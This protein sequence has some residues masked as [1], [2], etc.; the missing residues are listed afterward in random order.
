M[1]AALVP[2]RWQDTGGGYMA[3]SLPSNVTSAIDLRPIAILSDANS[4]GYAVAMLDGALPDGAVELE[5]GN[6][7]RDRD[8]WRAATGFRP[9][10]TNAREW[11]FSQLLDGSDDSGDSACRPLRGQTPFSVDMHLD[12]K[13]TRQ[14]A[15]VKQL[16]Q[17]VYARRDLDRIRQDVLD[18][19]LPPDT[20]RKCLVAMARDMGMDWRDLK[21][22]KW[23]ASESGIEPETT[24]TDPGKSGGFVVITSY[25]PPGAGSAYTT[26]GENGNRF[27]TGDASDG[28]GP[29]I[30]CDAGGLGIGTGN[31]NN[32]AW[33]PSSLS[34]ANC[35]WQLDQVLRAGSGAVV[36]VLG[37]GNG[38]QTNYFVDNFGGSIRGWYHIAGVGTSI[39]SPSQTAA[40]TRDDLW[41]K[42]LGSTISFGDVIGTA[43]LSVTNTAVTTGLRGGI[44]CYSS[45]GAKDATGLSARDYLTPTITT[46]SPSSGS[47]AGGTSVTITGTGFESNATVTFGG[48]SAASVVVA[49]ETSLTCVTPSGTAGAKNVVVT[50]PDGGFSVTSTGGYTY[51]TPTTTT[52]TTTT[53]TSTTTSTT[54]TLCYQSRTR[55]GLFSFLPGCGAINWRNS[56]F[57]RPSP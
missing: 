2:Y 3:W 1:V 47:T 26:T 36:G 33:H 19:K 41:V 17:A 32:W 9:V 42:C 13:S 46:I 25:T 34:S 44:F 8:A 50:N 57:K 49:S 29:K 15:R 48:A 39:G 10:G 20:H 22:A 35:Y 23:G 40:L 55:F 52:T 24:I 28:L 53:T 5:T 38:N 12:G 4:V 37:R 45:G 43:K 7:T 30:V 27:Q 18:G 16:Q 14:L 56:R 21:P 51:A 11:A 54:T 6:E 31:A